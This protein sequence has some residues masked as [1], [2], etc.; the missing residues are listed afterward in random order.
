LSYRVL[1]YSD[2]S[3]ANCNRC[4]NKC[5]GLHGVPRLVVPMLQLGLGTVSPAGANFP[6]C[7]QLD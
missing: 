4:Q 7:T 3:E 1:A 6:A 5:P 2:E